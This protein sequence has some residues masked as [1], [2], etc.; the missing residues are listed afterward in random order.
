MIWFRLELQLGL[1]MRALHHRGTSGAPGWPLHPE[2]VTA[3][4]TGNHDRRTRRGSR[5]G[6]GRRPRRRNPLL[7]GYICLLLL[8]PGFVPSAHAEQRRQRKHNPN[9]ELPGVV[10]RRTVFFLTIDI[11]IS[12]I[13]AFLTGLGL[14]LITGGD[15]VVVT[16]HQ[17]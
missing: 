12:I 7:L 5:C 15:L 1:A 2:R 13:V 4:W 11:I 3:R 17:D 16:G 10:H 14:V 8:C 6:R 9:P